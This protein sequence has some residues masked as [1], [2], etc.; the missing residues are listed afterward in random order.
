MSVR[1]NNKR[2]WAVAMAAATV[3][4]C[5]ATVSGQTTDKS[6]YHLFNPTPRAAMRGMET[7]RPDITESPYTVDA[8]HFQAE[9][10][11]FEYGRDGSGPGNTSE[12]DVLPTNLKVGLTNSVDLQFVFTPYI[13]LE[14]D[15]A[16]ADA[17]GF[18][19]T[20]LR[21]KVNLWGNDGPD[22]RFGDSALAVMPFVQFPT[23]DDDL[24]F[25]D[26]VEG[27]VIVPF[28]TSLPRGFGLG[29]MA[30]FDVVRDEDDD[31]YDLEFVHT[32]SVSRDI[33]RD[34]AGY[35]EYIGVAAP[36][37][38]AAALGAGLTYELSPDVRLDGGVNVGLNDEAEDFR[39]FTG[40][41]FRL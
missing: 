24:G 6:A 36:G 17:S 14:A 19:A 38:Y 22:G 39:V 35:V 4:A 8:G 29:L 34:W 3:A 7:D 21:L 16:D 27:G 12:W 23:S 32:A 2:A 9:L 26:H 33:M 18:G 28:A 20:Q 10:S 15:E 30:E 31:G 1:K 41:S 40:V 11:F 25:S 37:D 13:R 5:G